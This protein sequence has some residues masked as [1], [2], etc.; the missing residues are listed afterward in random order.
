ME[1][2]S[3][4]SDTD[5]VSI[6][7][8]EF[9]I[10]TKYNEETISEKMLYLDGFFKYMVSVTQIRNASISSFIS[11]ASPVD[12]ILGNIY[13]IRRN[14]YGP[15]REGAELT[16]NNFNDYY[17]NKLDLNN[18]NVTLEL[19]FVEIV[20]ICFSSILFYILVVLENNN[21]LIISLFGY[22]PEKET[23]Q[24]LDKCE[25]FLLHNYEVSA[26]PEH[27]KSLKTFKAKILDLQVSQMSQY[28]NLKR[29]QRLKENQRKSDEIKEEWENSVMMNLSENI[30]VTPVAY[31]QVTQRDTERPLN[32]YETAGHD[33]LGTGPVTSRIPEISF[34]DNFT[35]NTLRAGMDSRRPLHQALDFT[36]KNSALNTPD[37][38]LN[39]GFKYE[40]EGP[41]MAEEIH[42]DKAAKLSASRST[43]RKRL[44]WKLIITVCFASVLFCLE[45]FFFYK[46]FLNTSRTIY[47]HLNQNLGRSAYLKY[48]N[49]FVLEEIWEVD[50]RNVYHYSGFF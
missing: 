20:L 35:I 43:S 28:Q 5:F 24:L 15:L 8:Q 22:L 12:P 46:R 13:E 47:N 37:M 10:E 50:P 44:L 14:G 3:S 25:H 30:K 38:T 34:S 40:E 49:A 29:K 7:Q 11:R 31:F 45:Y 48:M 18:K 23:R 33:Y 27:I 21:N 39:P 4:L 1:T 6:D 26:I 9:I 2:I 32:R 42:Y 19:I 17:L 16:I 36:F 41:N